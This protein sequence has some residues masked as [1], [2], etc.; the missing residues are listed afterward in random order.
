MGNYTVKVLSDEDGMIV[1]GNIEKE[2]VP[3]EAWA[4][5]RIR[6]MLDTKGLRVVIAH[7]K[8]GHYILESI[9]GLSTF[10][11]KVLSKEALYKRVKKAMKRIEK[12]VEA[13]E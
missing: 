7:E 2:N 11:G 12:R 8:D 3:S 13:V 6:C 5:M 1:A 9:S 4:A 10:F